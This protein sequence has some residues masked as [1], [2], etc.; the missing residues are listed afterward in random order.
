MKIFINFLKFADF[1]IF[2]FLKIYRYKQIT[3]HFKN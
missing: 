2:S 3:P 1:S